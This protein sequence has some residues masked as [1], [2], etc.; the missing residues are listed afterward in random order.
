LPYGKMLQFQ[1]PQGRTNSGISPTTFTQG[2]TSAIKPDESPD[3][4]NTTGPDY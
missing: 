3:V 2:D 4:D 1:P